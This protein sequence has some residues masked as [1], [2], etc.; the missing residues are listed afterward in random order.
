MGR[1]IYVERLIRAPIDA[2]WNATQRPAVHE[3]WDLRFSEI[4]YL[5]RASE[6]DPQR[7]V[8]ATRM[9]LGVRIVG[10]GETAGGRDR[11]G[12]R[13]S[14]LRFW[15][16][17]T[18]SLIR[19]GSGYWRYVPV[20]GA[21][22]FITLYDYDTRFGMIGRLADFAFRPLIA[23]ATAWSFDR[24]RLWLERGID[25]ATSLERTAIHWVARLAVSFV[26]LYHGMVPKLLVGAG[27]VA[28]AE[29]MGVPPSL[30]PTLVVGAGIFE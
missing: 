27:E 20:D 26:W 25:P 11:D 28:L 5:P 16:N 24:L 13:T 4:R 23:W 3:R 21:V 12:D 18:K 19:E 14:A 15:S 2:L 10:T 1:P 22:R 9:G 29:R 30:A 7:F 6:R 8:Y 17:D